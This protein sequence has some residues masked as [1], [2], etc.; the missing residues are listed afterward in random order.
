MHPKL[1]LTSIYRELAAL[2]ASARARVP[3]PSTRTAPA[4]R[5]DRLGSRYGRTTH[6]HILHTTFSIPILSEIHCTPQQSS[7]DAMSSSPLFSSAE[8]SNLIQRSRFPPGMGCMQQRLPPHR[9]R[10][11]HPSS[12]TR[13]RHVQSE[14]IHFET[15]TS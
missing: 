3:E 12:Q 14:Y 1:V 10:T 15:H 7:I 13:S 9:G 2:L 11:Q 4:G 5:V 6:R 8:G